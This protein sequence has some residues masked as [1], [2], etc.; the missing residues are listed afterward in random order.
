MQ[1]TRMGFSK[2]ECQVFTKKSSERHTVSNV[3]TVWSF[4]TG[5]DHSR[6]Q[7][8]YRF[9]PGIRESRKYVEARERSVYYVGYD[10]CSSSGL[11]YP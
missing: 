9:L 3:F 8:L 10:L 11:C 2:E 1:L 6:A 4:R 7:D 5:L